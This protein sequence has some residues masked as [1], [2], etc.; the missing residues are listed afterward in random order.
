M[1][2]L[3]KTIVKQWL[4]YNTVS[5]HNQLQFKYLAIKQTADFSRKESKVSILKR[6][7]M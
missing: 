1:V 5:A 4:D 7:W 2:V 6:Q 3:F